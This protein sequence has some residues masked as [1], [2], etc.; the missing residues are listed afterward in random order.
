MKF[1]YY[2]SQCLSENSLEACLDVGLISK[3]QILAVAVAEASLL[4]EAVALEALHLARDCEL[5]MSKKQSL[6]QLSAYQDPRLYHF[7]RHR[8]HR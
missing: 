4:S 2:E 3:R 1:F 5:P 8:T 6:L 7:L